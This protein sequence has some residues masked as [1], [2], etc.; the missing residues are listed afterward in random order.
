MLSDE[1]F[2]PKFVEN[3]DTMLL[4]HFG[5]LAKTAPASITPLA[6]TPQRIL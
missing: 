2:W 3:L 5:H 1:T 6:S 4:L